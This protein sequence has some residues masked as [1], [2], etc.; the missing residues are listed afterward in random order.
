[1]GAVKQRLSRLGVRLFTVK[2]VPMWAFVLEVIAYL[3]ILAGVFILPSDL[4]TT[5]V[6]ILFLIGVAGGIAVTALEKRLTPPGSRQAQTLADSFREQ[7][8]L[9]RIL[10]VIMGLTAVLTVI[11]MIA[12]L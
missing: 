10:T 4:T 11:Q 1:M 6:T 7:T 2:R 5:S 3:V 8:L 9:I 12:M